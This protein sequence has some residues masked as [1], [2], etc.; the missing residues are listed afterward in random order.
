MREYGI[1]KETAYA[2]TSVWKNPLNGFLCIQDSPDGKLLDF[3]DKAYH[4]MTVEQIYA[5]HP[6]KG[7]YGTEWEDKP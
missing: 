6:A 3:I 1:A 4:E 5:R 7:R 2:W